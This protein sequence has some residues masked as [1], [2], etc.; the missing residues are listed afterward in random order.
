MF[1]HSLA[2][3][4]N[5]KVKIATLNIDTS[6]SPEIKYEGIFPDYNIDNRIPGI[7]AKL[8]SFKNQQ[9]DIITIQEAR[10]CNENNIKIDAVNPLLENLKNNGYSTACIHYNNLSSNVFQFITALDASKFKIISSERILLSQ[11]EKDYPNIESLSSI[12]KQQ[13]EEAIKFHYLDQ[14]FPRSFFVTEAEDIITNKKIF[15]VNVHLGVFP[16]SHKE[17]AI[18]HVIK[19]LTTLYNDNPDSIIFL[20]GDFN[21]FP[22]QQG[23]EQIQML[24]D[25]GFIEL[26]QKIVDKDGNKILGNSSFI[27]YPYDFTSYKK[28]PL[29]RQTFAQVKQLQQSNSVNNKKDNKKLAIARDKFI[30]T[31]STL[32]KRAESLW[33]QEHNELNSNALYPLGGQL[34]HIFI[35]AKADTFEAEKVATLQLMDME[36]KMLAGDKKTIVNHIDNSLKNN[37]AAFATDHQGLV[38]SIKIYTTSRLTDESINK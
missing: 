16:A 26:S 10:I 20:A 25:S 37:C 23:I 2:D 22:D 19:H 27:G 28:D 33:Q 3:F 6:L 14:L 4:Q 35:L 11:D 12:E 31:R 17:K 21:S 8:N 7:K 9:V 34:D 15:I 24:E 13:Q 5:R 29:V 1:Q 18:S 38:S 32:T 30:K 36:G